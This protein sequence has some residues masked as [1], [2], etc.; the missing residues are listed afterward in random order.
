MIGIMADTHDNLNS[1]RKAVQL[2]NKEE[3]ELVIHAGDLIAPFTAGEF[4]KL[5]SK[6]VAIF[7]NNDGERDGLKKAYRDICHLEDFK[8]ISVNHKSIAVI[9]GTNEALVDA[10]ARSGKYDVVIRGHT[11]KLEII[12]GK[13]M[14]INPGEACGYLSGNETVV[15]LDPVHLSYEVVYL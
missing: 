7:G 1:I 10:L 13:T 14:I 6:L 5:N 2:F 8:E 4:Q 12:N 15:L 9:H 3:V 11:H